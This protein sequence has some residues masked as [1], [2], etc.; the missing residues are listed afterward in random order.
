M[1]LEYFQMITRVISFDAE[2]KTLTAAADVP[3]ESPVFE[4]HFPGYPL[5]PGVL[6]IEAMAQT[7]GWLILGLNG[8]TA[9]PFLTGANSAKM[10]DFVPPSTPLQVHAHLIGDGSGYAVTKA[11]ITREGK[12]VAEAEIRFAVKTFPDPKFAQMIREWGERLEFP[13]EKLAAA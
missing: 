2:A 5:L 11:H 1:R 10:R 9:M 13:F 8:L 4:G 7:S 6:M 12:K 3:A